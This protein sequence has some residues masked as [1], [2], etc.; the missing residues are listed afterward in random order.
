M[1]LVINPLLNCQDTF[2]GRFA[3][4]FLNRLAERISPDFWILVVAGY[5]QSST[6]SA[7]RRLRFNSIQGQ[8]LQRT[9]GE[10]PP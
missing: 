10:S 7:S 5:H 4:A 1:I 9:P 8:H 6:G 3:T 2:F